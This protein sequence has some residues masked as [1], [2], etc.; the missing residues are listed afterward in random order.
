MKIKFITKE[1]IFKYLSIILASILVITTVLSIVFGVKN[2]NKGKLVEELSGQ[3][4]SEEAKLNEKVSEYDV[5]KSQQSSE[6]QSYEDE[7]HSQKND[8]KELKDKIEDLKSQLATKNNSE[9][10]KDDGEV[11]PVSPEPIPSKGKTVYLTFDDGPS[12]YTSEILDILDKYGV[13]ATFF[14]VNGKYNSTM[15]DIVKR[16][17]SIGL[18]TYTHNYSKIYASDSAYFDDLQKISDVVKKETGTETRLMRFP[19][20]SSNTISKKY[21]EGIMTRLTKSVLE[22]GYVYF[23]WNCSNGDADGADTVAKQLSFCSKFPKNAKN[24]VLLMHDTKKVTMEALPHI[25]EYYKSCGME[26]AALTP[27]T[28]IVNHPVFN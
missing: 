12:P 11:R 14:V 22:K 27:S 6:A 16:G 25:I 21:S 1:E 7:I 3:L 24:I 10:E 4:A 26:F 18:H 5:L 13:K 20:G 19:G 8:I 28:E 15:K 17:H 23:D 2:H 9:T